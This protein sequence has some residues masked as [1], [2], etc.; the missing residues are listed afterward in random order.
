MITAFL[1]DSASLPGLMQDLDDLLF[2]MPLAP[3]PSFANDFIWTGGLDRAPARGFRRRVRRLGRS[4][5]D[6]RRS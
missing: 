5:S 6:N 4:P 3:G 1:F 2:G